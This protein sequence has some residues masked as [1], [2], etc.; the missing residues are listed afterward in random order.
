[1]VVPQPELTP[2]RL[3]DVAARLLGEPAALAS[4]RA[5]ARSLA[6]PDAAGRLAALILE[7]AGGTAC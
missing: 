4:M 1:V 2:A 7:A 5:R 6:V 3:L